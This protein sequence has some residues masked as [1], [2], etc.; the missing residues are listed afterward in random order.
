M[1]TGGFA[2]RHDAVIMVSWRCSGGCGR[3]Q[4]RKLPSLK[5]GYRLLAVLDF[6]NR[7][8]PVC[9]MSRT[10]RR[11]PPMCLPHSACSTGGLRNDAK[12]P[13]PAGAS[14]PYRPSEAY[15]RTPPPPPRRAMRWMMLLADYVSRF[16]RIL[17]IGNTYIPGRCDRAGRRWGDHH[18]LQVA[19]SRA[20]GEV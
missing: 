13:V 20:T 3:W 17:M 7:F 1:I 18:R 12:A 4:G 15:H 5:G 16:L 11:R 10:R 2:G 14:F 19:P 9:G 8:M 6:W